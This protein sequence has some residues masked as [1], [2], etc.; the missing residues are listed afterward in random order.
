MTVPLSSP[1]TAYDDLA[2]PDQLHD[3]CVAADARLHLSA[4]AREA[5]RTAPS[6]RLEE[7]A[8]RDDE[9]LAAAQLLARALNLE[10]E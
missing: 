7:Q 1:R 8:G 5:I 2:D 3:D 4:P 10:A 9:L 6:I